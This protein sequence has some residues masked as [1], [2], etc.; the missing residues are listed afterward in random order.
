MNIT[1]LLLPQNT[2]VEPFMFDRPIH[3][4]ELMPLWEAALKRSGYEFKTSSERNSLTD[5]L[6]TTQHHQV[7]VHIKVIGRHMNGSF[8]CHIGTSKA[9]RPIRST[10]L[11]QQMRLLAVFFRTENSKS[12]LVS[13][14]FIFF[15]TW[16]LHLF[17]YT[18]HDTTPGRTDVR[19]LENAN[20][21]KEDHIYRLNHVLNTLFRFNLHQLD[22][23]KLKSA[24]E[25]ADFLFD[26]AGLDYRNLPRPIF[27][28]PT[29]QPS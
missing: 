17:R 6:L 11:T 27:F 18:Q 23:C 16:L 14:E 5:A 13:P 2:T 29:H 8:R 21:A 20:M 19:F 25:L 15:P 26:H 3:D 12:Q 28:G 1:E 7:P 24:I 9:S 10:E 22:P 4:D